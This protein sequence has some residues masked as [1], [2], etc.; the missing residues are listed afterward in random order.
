MAF[1]FVLGAVI[2][3]AI[4][5]GWSLRILREYERGVVFQLGRFWMV[6]GRD[7]SSY[8]P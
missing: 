4:L 7:S 2:F 1:N 5:V 6:K 3:L 8:G